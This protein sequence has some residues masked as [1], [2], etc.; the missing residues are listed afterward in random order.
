MKCSPIDRIV[1][2]FRNHGQNERLLWESTLTRQKAS[3]ICRINEIAS[4]QRHRIEQSGTIHFASCE[5][6]KRGPHV[7]PRRNP[8]RT[9]PCKYCGDTHAAGN[10]H[11]YSI[12]CSKCNKKNHLAKDSQSTCK[13]DSNKPKRERKKPGKHQRVNQLQQDQPPDEL[14]GD[15]S[16]FTL[17]AP[18]SH[19]VQERVCRF[20]S[21]NCKQWKW[22]PSQPSFKWTLIMKPRVKP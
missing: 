9:R 22:N 10:C 20:S 13:Q 1:T 17:Y 8:C 14:S 7:N 15:E 19:K 4:F 5:E 3:D 6:K 12:T 11:A 16:V 21:R 2:G 18:H